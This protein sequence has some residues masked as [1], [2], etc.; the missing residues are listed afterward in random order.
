MDKNKTEIVLVID[1]SGSM[2]CLRDTVITSVNGFLKDQKGCEGIACVTVY[3]FNDDVQVVQECCDIREVPELTRKNYNPG[4]CT[5]LLKAP[6]NLSDKQRPRL[7]TL[8]AMN[9]P[10]NTAYVLKEQAR[11]MYKLYY[12]SDAAAALQEWLELARQSGLQ[13]FLRLAKAM[14]RDAGYILNYF[15]HKLSSGIIEGV[16]SKIAK[17]QFQTRGIRDIRYLYLKLRESTCMRFLD[18]LA[19]VG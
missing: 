12:F 18:T 9:A 6:G 8:L 14:T 16:N 10:I 11:E 15:R 19:P 2:S 1:K 3:A 4:G 5:A 17:N 13:P 7:E